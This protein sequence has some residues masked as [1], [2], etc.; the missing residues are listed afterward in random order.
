MVNIVTSSIRRSMLI[1]WEHEHIIWVM[2]IAST[3]ELLL[4]L[5]HH[6]R[7]LSW[8]RVLLLHSHV[9]VF[10]ISRATINCRI[11][12]YLLM[13][14]LSQLFLVIPSINV[15]ELK[16]ILLST[17][18]VLCAFVLLLK[19]SL[20]IM[21]LRCIDLLSWCNFCLLLDVDTH[22]HVIWFG[23][24][25]HMHTCNAVTRGH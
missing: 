11:W 20:V 19:W 23:F 14:L 2:C 3:V 4:L 12:N 25:M 22:H 5:L 1:S 6:L 24:R 8:H 17:W 10:K 13:K 9:L 7:Y 15:I 16:P 18:V 21:V